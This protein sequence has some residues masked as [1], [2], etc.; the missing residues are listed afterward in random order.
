MSSVDLVL[1][2]APSV[3]DFRE[4]AI[5]YGP[6]SDLVP[7]TPVFE[8]YPI[9]FTT[10]ADYLERFG[11]RTR[12]VNLA[13]RMLRE[14]GFDA[15]KM[16]ASLDPAVFGIDLHWLPHAHGAIEVARLVKKHHPNTPV[17]FG[18]FS[19]TYFHQD[20]ASRPEVDFVLRGD[21]TEEPLR[22]LMS[23]LRGDKSAPALA[24]IP[25]LT[26]RDKATGQVRVNP[27]TYKP[28]NLDDLSLDYHRIVR[29]VMRDRNLPDYLPF[30]SWLDYPIMAGLSCRGCVHHCTTCGG[31][32]DAFKTVF[33]RE[34]PA[35]RSPE[36][37]A[38]DVRRIH[39]FS[40]GPVFVLGDL[41]QGG[42][43]YAR[44]FLS[45]ISGMKEQV[46]IELFSPASKE[47]L[48]QVAHALP[49]FVLEMSLESHDP[50]VRHSFNKHYTNAAMEQTMA[51]ALDSG[52][53]RLDVYFMTGLPEQSYSSVMQTV[54]YAS[55]LLDRY[56]L[57]G[58]LLP[59]I[60]P[61]APFVDPGSLAF[62]NPDKHGYRFSARTLEQHRDHLIAPSWKYVLNY[63]TRWMT[64]DEIVASTY[65]AGRRLNA[66]K[67]AH[68][69][70]PAELAART[71]SRINR[72]LE[73]VEVVDLLV[74][75]G[76]ET[77]EREMLVLKPEI[78]QVNEST[79]C[80]KRE[81]DLPVGF[82]R[83]DPLTIAQA[84]LEGT[85]EGL[86]HALME[87]GR[88]I[89]APSSPPKLTLNADRSSIVK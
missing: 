55:Q 68:N 7:S 2:H 29:S 77:L 89:Y 32:A 51:D 12:I 3:Y 42:M 21:S 17:I 53:K 78:D 39:R 19:S 82:S 64:R 74:A 63:E 86:A 15:E 1:M 70:I 11:F 35:F 71:E 27:I 75:E 45:A 36:K 73:L 37:L 16:I 26:Y 52:C 49:N 23:Y 18:G 85:T 20:L 69:L 40:K 50:R 47:F 8:M 34:R 30:A 87:Y 22:Q 62:E 57:D 84:W 31:S 25:N 33:G 67:A 46:M 48:Q 9:G 66:L 65:E 58:R 76:G 13:V 43:D 60:S 38:T 44:R 14:K 88:R 81:L 80:E 59:F 61:L 5:L 72:A 24:D 79:V 41:R 6:I 56:N 28:S 83:F 54:E 4:K 10:M